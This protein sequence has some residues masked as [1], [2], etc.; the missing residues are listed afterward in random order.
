MLPLLEV[1][2]SVKGINKGILDAKLAIE[3]WILTNFGIDLGQ[4][5]KQATAIGNSILNGIKGG[6]TFIARTWIDQFIASLF[7]VE[8]WTG[9][10]TAVWST[11]TSVGNTI[12][13][14]LVGAITG[15]V[16]DPKG[17]ASWWGKIGKAIWDGITGWMAAN[18]PDAKKAMENFAQ[19]FVD[20]INTVIFS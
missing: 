19:G 6:L 5:E 3:G 7:K 1:S 20:G 10:L 12:W 13:T 17:A 4:I 16:T 9:A 14:F 8:T 15:A 2:Q 11:I 18:L